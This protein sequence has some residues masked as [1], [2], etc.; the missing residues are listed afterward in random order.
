MPPLHSHRCTDNAHFC[1]AKKGAHGCTKC[2]SR[3]ASTLSCVVAGGGL[4][5]SRLIRA[6]LFR[7]EPSQPSIQPSP[8]ASP[9]FPSDHLTIHPSSPPF[10][11]LIPPQNAKCGKS[12]FKTLLWNIRFY[13]S[14]HYGELCNKAML[15]HHSQQLRDIWRHIYFSIGIVKILIIQL[16]SSIFLNAESSWKGNRSTCM[17]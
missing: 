10:Y 6:S 17:S 12:R 9:T 11:Y 1:T 16:V 7:G 3:D 2:T 5:Q 8:A 13:S 4:A 14:L 15:Y